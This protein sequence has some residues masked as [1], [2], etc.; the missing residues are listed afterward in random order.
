MNEKI[1]SII[2]A[3]RY[4]D[5]KPMN[6]ITL[7]NVFFHK[8]MK[9]KTS[10]LLPINV[11][12][13]IT[14]FCNAKC[15][16]CFDEKN[17][18]HPTNIHISSIKKIVNEYKHP[19]FFFLTGGEP[20]LH[21]HI[22]EIIEIIKKAGHSC[23]V[24]T[25]ATLLDK[26]KISKLDNLQLDYIF[27]SLHGT[28]KDHNKLTGIESY[29]TV[30]KVIKEFTTFAPK[31][32]IHIN[33]VLDKENIQETP[34]ALEKLRNCNI[35][36]M[37]ISHPNFI[38]ENEIPLKN[39]Q[40]CSVIYKK[41]PIK[42]TTIISLMKRIKRLHPTLPF[43]ILYK[44]ELSEQEIAWWYSSR[45]NISRKCYFL[46]SSTHIDATG[47]VFPC[48]YLDIPLGNITKTTLKKIWN[49]EKYQEI[50]KQQENKPFA[51]C[52]RCCKI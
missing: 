8:L 39:N 29:D 30:I 26:T 11:N 21:P 41:T 24:V 22:F 38:L 13:A 45:N 34:L 20:F 44:P 46:Y 47:N 12:I 2:N 28:R 3:I 40:M 10:I 49:N 1:A 35:K 4:I 15:P 7:G 18:T 48:T 33:Y 25:N 17:R 42:K 32:D 36:T 52:K 43:P 14:S 27:I 50:R 51:I 31:C 5:L 19:V 23:G 9:H 37:R 6:L 16:F